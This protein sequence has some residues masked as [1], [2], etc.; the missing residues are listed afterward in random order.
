MSIETKW[1]KMLKETTV[2]L[3][4]KIRS[5]LSL[6][7]LKSRSLEVQI[8][9]LNHFLLVFLF[10]DYYNSVASTSFANNDGWDF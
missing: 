6:C 8:H 4:G 10:V 9:S 1:F 3:L 2:N 7:K 5:L